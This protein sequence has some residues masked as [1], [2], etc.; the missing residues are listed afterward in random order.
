MCIAAGSCPL[1]AATARDLIQSAA[2]W[3][4]VCCVHRCRIMSTVSC[5]YQRSHPVSCSLNC[6][7]LCA[8]LQDHVRCELPLPEISSSQLL[9]EQWNTA[10][11]FSFCL[12]LDVPA[13]IVQSTIVSAPVIVEVCNFVMALDDLT[14]QKESYVLSQ[15]CMMCLFTLN[16]LC[17]WYLWMS[18]G[19]EWHLLVLSATD[20]YRSLA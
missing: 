16:F 13:C 9:S 14:I 6:C 3:T 7:V 1:W 11:E 15:H 17:L 19:V 20:G 12:P 4:V 8:L 2:L 5:H 10:P 18:G